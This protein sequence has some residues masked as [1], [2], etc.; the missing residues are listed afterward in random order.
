[1]SFFAEI[2]DFNAGA[3]LLRRRR[4]GV[5]EVANER[6]VRICLRP[7]PKRASWFEARLW[8]RF[9]HDR[10]NGNVCRLFYNE[11]RTAP[12]FLALS[13]VVSNHTTSVAT[14]RGALGVLDEIARLKRSD[15]LVG[16][17]SNLRISDRLLKRWGWAPLATS[18]LHRPFIKRFYGTY[19]PLDDG[20]RYVLKLSLPATLTAQ[21]AMAISAQ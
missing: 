21:A 15:A 7:W 3:E 6:L 2:R 10:R 11:P 20:L 4:Y 14:V 5:I 19:P 18:R 1:M 17:V 8:G 16:D 13:F 12:G 9:V